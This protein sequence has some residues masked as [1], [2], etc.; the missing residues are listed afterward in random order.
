MKLFIVAPFASVILSLLLNHRASA[1]SDGRQPGP[2]NAGRTAE[3]GVNPSSN[4]KVAEDGTGD[5]Q[6]MQT[7]AALDIERR[8]KVKV[9]SVKRPASR[10]G[11]DFFPTTETDQEVLTISVSTTRSPTIPYSKSWVETG[12]GSEGSTVWVWLQGT[13]KSGHTSR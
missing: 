13:A 3:A 7:G 10:K 6:P 5:K 9:R 1:R 2:E 4:P 11:F 8:A 12:L